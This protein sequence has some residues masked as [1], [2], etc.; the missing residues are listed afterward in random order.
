ME[1]PTHWHPSSKTNLDVIHNGMN[2]NADQIAG[3]A[4]HHNLDANITIRRRMY[5]H[6]VHPLIK[7]EREIE[8][9]R[10]RERKRERERE[11]EREN[12]NKR[13]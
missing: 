10:E 8:I 1:R 4:E 6:E 3:V 2:S 12:T 5:L 11:R 13:D 7:R 9:E